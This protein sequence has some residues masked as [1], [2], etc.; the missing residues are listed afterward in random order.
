MSK[1]LKY[2]IKK[3]LLALLGIMIGG[4]TYGEIATHETD[5]FFSA[6]PKGGSR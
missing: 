2:Y 1:I 4:N 3:P 5:R 6:W